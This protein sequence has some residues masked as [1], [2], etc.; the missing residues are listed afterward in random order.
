MRIFWVWLLILLLIPVSARGARAD[1]TTEPPALSLAPTE[2]A[3]SV[4]G[5]PAAGLLNQS[6]TPFLTNLGRLYT[7]PWEIGG[8]EA[9]VWLAAVAL[10]V[11]YDQPVY[12]YFQANLSSP[13]IDRAERRRSRSWVTGLTGFAVTGLIWLTDPETGQECLEAMV[14]TGLNVAIF[15]ALLGMARPDL[16]QGPVFTGPSLDNDFAAM[17]SG[18]TAGAFALATVL[19]AKYPQYR[20]AFYTLATLVGLSRIYLEQHWPSNVLAGAVIGIY[21]GQRVLGEE[22]TILQWKF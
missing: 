21:C 10:L 1:F 19:G 4:A 17:P 2:T 15:K 16:G 12:D 7:E 22:F 9:A 3:L 20:W 5:Q 11:H 14:F 8:T 6:T 13:G 18:H